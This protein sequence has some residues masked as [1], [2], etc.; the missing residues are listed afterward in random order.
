MFTGY[1]DKLLA[2]F[3]TMKL[4]TYIY[5]YLNQSKGQQSL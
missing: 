4:Y 1:C 5:T 3:N 2:I